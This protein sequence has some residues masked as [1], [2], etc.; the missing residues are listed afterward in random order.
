MPKK[1]IH[2]D[3][4][5]EFAGKAQQR[6]RER[7]WDSETRADIYFATDSIPIDHENAKRVADKYIARDG[8][9]VS[10]VASHAR[11]KEAGHELLNDLEKFVAGFVVYP[12]EHGKVAHVLWIAHTHLME[13]WDS[14]PRLAFLSPEPASGKTGALEVSELL[15]PSP[16]EA[17]NVS[18]AYLFRKVGEG[19]SPTIL[20]DEIDTIFGPKAKKENEDIRGLLNAGHRRGA[21]AGRCL[22]HGKAVTPEE[23]PAYCA[24][25]LAGI[26]WLPDTILSRAVIIRMRRR[27]PGER[28]KAFRRRT[29]LEAGNK[30]R[31]RL[32]SWTN[33]LKIDL[34]AVEMPAGVEDRD[35]DVWEALIAIAD[36]AGGDWPERARKAAAALIKEAKDIEPSLGIRLLADTRTIFGDATLVLSTESLLHALHGLP[37]SPWA[38]LKGK[39]LNDRGLAHRLRQYGVK[40]KAIR[41]GDSTLRGYTREDLFDPWQ[42][43]LPPSLPDGSATSATSETDGENANV[44]NGGTVADAEIPSATCA[45]STATSEFSAA[46]RV[47]DVA[48]A[49]A[50]RGT[51]NAHT[52]SDVADVADVALPAETEG[53]A[54]TCALCGAGLRTVPASDPPTVSAQVNG[55]AHWFHPECHGVWQRSHPPLKSRPGLTLASSK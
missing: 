47:S 17:V 48:D 8:K 14:T 24:V 37:E 32:A 26:G 1:A 33:S 46:D 28:I 19:T 3:Q 7:K 13:S 25:A 10:H 9:P 41:I 43:Y 55:Q 27:K 21:V 42:T 2:N 39:P 36:T 11:T 54:L 40:P 6:A 29:E 23:I 30:L 5:A 31:N 44:S 18:A 16:V 53:D 15:V 20:F 51:K 34:D 45:T 38:D 4:R 50:D 52:I 35:A 49:V 12:S 22:V